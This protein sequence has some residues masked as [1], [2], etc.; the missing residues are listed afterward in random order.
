MTTNEHN[1][2]QHIGR[3]ESERRPLPSQAYADP[4]EINLLEYIYALVK[5]KWIIIGATVACLVVGYGAA[6]IK[7]PAWVGTATIAPKEADSQ[8]APSISGFCALGGIV[9]S[10]L[11]IGGN[12]SLDKIDIILNSRKF[13][14]E[15][16]QAHNLV[17]DLIRQENPKFYKEYW[18]SANTRWRVDSLAP[19]PVK[20]AGIVKEDY[21]EKN[22]EK[23]NTMTI[24]I[25]SS[26]S[27]FTFTLS[28]AILAHLNDYIKSTVQEEAKENVSYLENRLI[29]ITDPLLRAKI[30]ELIANEVEKMM[31]VSK[32]AFKVIDPLY[33]S[34]SFR[35]K[36]L[37][38]LV[39]GFGLFFL[40]V[41]GVVFGHAFGSSPKTEEDRKLIEGIKQ[42]MRLRKKSGSV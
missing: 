33:F 39:F 32:E 40:T 27:L 11:N 17:D 8:K 14:A 22:I 24:E 4:D 12:A 38:P 19:D 42:E 15:M 9:A 20:V 25:K 18:D 21:L 2:N 28:T 3:P 10:Q 41:L 29:G 6:L 23:N 26:D 36:K 35:E 31:V 1:S 16:L 13:N 7:G 5:H 30:Q 37:Y 34:K